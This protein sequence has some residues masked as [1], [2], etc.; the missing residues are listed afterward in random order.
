MNR[1]EYVLEAAFAPQE[2][3]LRELVRQ[4][5]IAVEQVEA[6]GEHPTKDPAVL[7]LGAYV[8]FHTHADVN[9]ASGYHRMLE[10]CAARAEEARSLN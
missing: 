6:E 3:P 9:T 2:K 4:L 7:I 10:M 8:A 5:S 1:F